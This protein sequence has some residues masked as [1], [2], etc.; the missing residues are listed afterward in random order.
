MILFGFVEANFIEWPPADGH[1]INNK[2]CEDFDL[3]PAVISLMRKI[4]YIKSDPYGHGDMAFNIFPE[5]PQVRYLNYDLL[6]LGRYADVDDT[7][8]QLLE[9]HD[10]ALTATEM[11][12]TSIILD[13][14]ESMCTKVAYHRFLRRTS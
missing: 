2:L 14:K 10:F 7:R 1:P 6:R 13:T 8:N 3:D 4:P 5:L 11:Y 12:G 9:K